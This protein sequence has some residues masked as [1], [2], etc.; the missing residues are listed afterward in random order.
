MD[1]I[2]IRVLARELGIQSK[3]AVFV[4]NDLGIDAKTYVSS[5]SQID[6]ERIRTSVR[7][8]EYLENAKNKMEESEKRIKEKPVN[9]I[10]N[11]CPPGVQSQG[12]VS[13]PMEQKKTEKTIGH[14]AD[15]KNLEDEKRRVEEA[16]KR[17]EEKKRRE[18]TLRKQRTTFVETEDE[19]DSSDRY[20]K[21]SRKSTS[22]RYW[23]ESD[24]YDDD[25]YVPGIC[26]GRCDLC[27]ES[28]S[29]RTE[30][31]DF[32]EDHWWEL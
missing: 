7:N 31:Y 8:A 28:C 11:V 10:T 3:L 14:E 18:E 32:Y 27:T 12:S 26:Y 30:E 24:K 20:V 13:R 29:K 25:Y 9:V 5:V 19:D 4:A 1:D 21:D 22:N 16:K 23:E 15:R 6:A 2:R 17:E